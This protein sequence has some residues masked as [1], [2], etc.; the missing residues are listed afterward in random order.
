RAPS[1][2]MLRMRG[3]RV[4]APH[5]RRYKAA[6]MLAIDNI[7]VRIAGREILSGATANLP[8]GRRIGLVGRNGAGKSTLFNVILGRLHQDEGEISVPSS[9]RVGAVAQEAPGTD[10]SLLDTV[11][12]ADPERLRLLAEAEH[13][14]DGHKLGEI[15]HRLE[16][17]DAYTAPARAAEIL[18]GLGFSAEDQ[19]RPCPQLSG[20]W[21]MRGAL[22]AILFSAPGLLLLGEPTHHLRPESGAWSGK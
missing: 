22:A 13:E 6:Q 20:G 21:R 10:V 15:Y 2:H 3:R 9:W 12:E 19:L 11:L 4:C 8:A 7:T 16:A 14:T 17:I 1:P 18:A 5:K